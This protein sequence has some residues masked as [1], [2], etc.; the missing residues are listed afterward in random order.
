MCGFNPIDEAPEVGTE[1]DWKC[2]LIVGEGAGTGMSE[3]GA[4]IS[5]SKAETLK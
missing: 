1:K 4:C 5:G 3:R 2:D